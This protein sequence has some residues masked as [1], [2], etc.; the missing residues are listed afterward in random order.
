MEEEK[1]KIVKK[2][3]K[4]KTMEGQRFLIFPAWLGCWLN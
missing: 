2:N 4:K 1:N 3:K